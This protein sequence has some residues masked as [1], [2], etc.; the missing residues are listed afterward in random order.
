MPASRALKRFTVVRVETGWRVGDRQD[1]P[2]PLCLPVWTT[3]R[4]AR[5]AAHL[6]NRRL[7]YFTRYKNP[8]E[9]LRWLLVE[10]NDREK[11]SYS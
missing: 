10:V 7:S 4:R 8:V 9:N 3:R 1:K 2:I 11:E 6:L 5:I